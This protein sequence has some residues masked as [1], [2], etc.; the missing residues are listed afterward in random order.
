MDTITRIIL[1]IKIKKQS[2]I[3]TQISVNTMQKITY[4][5]LQAT[6]IAKPTF[7]SGELYC[8]TIPDVMY[9]R[10]SPYGLPVYIYAV[11]SM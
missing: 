10:T 7:T 11:K 1:R 6:H 2:L 9:I 8:F 5:K 3:F 4:T